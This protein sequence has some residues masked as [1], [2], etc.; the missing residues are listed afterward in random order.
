VADEARPATV[1]A[2][3]EVAV[4]PAEAFDLFIEELAGALAGLGLMLEPGADGR[5]LDGDAEVG[6]VSAWEP[7]ERVVLEW[8]PG[9][10]E[11]TEPTEVRVSFVA[12]ESATRV[13]VEH[14]GWG[15]ALGGSD[16]L[17][18][19]FAGE[20]A[21]PLLRSTGPAALGDWLTDRQARR[22]SGRRAREVYRDPLFHRPN[23]AVLLDLLALQPEDVLLEVGCGGGAF[24]HDALRS[25]CRA[26]AV[27][28]SPD[29]VR[30]AREVNA[31]PVA[32]GRLE[33]VEASADA[34]PF[35]DEMF[36]CATMT[37]VLG[38]L[39][40]PA[41]ALAEIRRVLADGGRLVLLG[42]DPAWR[43]T[44]A[45]PEPMAS[46]LRF[47]EDDELVRIGESAA[48]TDV[49][50][51]RRDLEEPARGAGVP[52]EYLPLFALAPAPFLVARKP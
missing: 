24:L 20:V 29:M 19:W 9:P 10:W 2:E 47:Y 42:S 30:L 51:E 43:G 27:D 13:V 8:R 11:D 39:A 46:R 31:E 35:P 44:P 32:Q 14:R 45:A 37:G 15:G 3:V 28:H 6:C 40:D 33:V 7:G 50:V 17:L 41:V 38:F 21:A 18:G 23:F 16:E 25:G 34:L 36:T 22:P 52:D 48:L 49:R 1:R 26:A 5:V 12:A 4:Q